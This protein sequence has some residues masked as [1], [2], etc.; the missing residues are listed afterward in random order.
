MQ[1]LKTFLDTL[2]GVYTPIAN[3][4]GMI[5]AGFAGVDFPYI[6]RAVVFIIVLWSLLRIL[7]V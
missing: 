7:G 1:T 3:S 2:L 6:V 5:P 4:T